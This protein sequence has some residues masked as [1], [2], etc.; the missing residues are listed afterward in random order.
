MIELRLPIFLITKLVKLG[1]SF[2][3]CK[4]VEVLRWKRKIENRDGASI[5]REGLV[6]QEKASIV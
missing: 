6:L 3:N 5:D 1:F 2:G 4:P